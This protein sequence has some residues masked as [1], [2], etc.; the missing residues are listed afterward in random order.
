MKKK[1]SIEKDCPD[2]IDT[3]KTLAY[4]ENHAKGSCMHR[5]MGHK[6]GEKG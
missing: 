5:T 1:I 2:H 3:I 6:E 4:I